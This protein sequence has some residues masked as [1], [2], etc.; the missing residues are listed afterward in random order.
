MASGVRGDMPVAFIENASRAEQRVLV[1]TVEG[2]QRDAVM[3][4]IKA[5]AMLIIGHVAKTAAELQWFG[6]AA[7][8]SGAA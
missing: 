2:M 4:K 6:R 7:I 8:A 1:S 5:P 3:Q